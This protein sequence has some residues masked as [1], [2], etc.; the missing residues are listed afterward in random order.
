V[1][2][3]YHDEST[4]VVTM[5]KNYFTYI[6]VNCAVQL[7]HQIVYKTETSLIRCEKT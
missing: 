4:F 5:I 1:L 2:N 7:L 3:E 6:C